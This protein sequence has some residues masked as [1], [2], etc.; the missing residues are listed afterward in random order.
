MAKLWSYFLFLVWIF[1]L[2]A[3]A[4]LLFTD[5]FLLNKVARTERSKSKNV[6]FILFIIFVSTLVKLINFIIF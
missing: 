6:Y 2:L 3:T 4:L 1:Y 5:G